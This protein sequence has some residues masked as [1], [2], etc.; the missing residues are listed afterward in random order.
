MA[1]KNTGMLTELLKNATLEKFDAYLADNKRELVQAH[2]FDSYV[3]NCIAQKKL[4]KKEVFLAAG[5]SE[6][7]G[8]KLLTGEKKPPYRDIVL[9]LCIGAEM[10]LEETQQALRLCGMAVLYPRVSRDALLMMLLAHGP[11][12]VGQ[13]DEILRANGF[14]ALQGAQVLE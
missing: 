2:G 14:D 11:Y 6:G 5:V 3:S 12:D 9:R 7:Y 4:K 13:V 1:D 8:Y 10:T